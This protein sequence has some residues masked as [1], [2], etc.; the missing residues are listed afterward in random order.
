M[1]G[2]FSVATALVLLDA[3]GLTADNA[4]CWGGWLLRTKFKMD[5]GTIFLTVKPSISLRFIM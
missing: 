3:L 4:L 5:T 1:W 2:P